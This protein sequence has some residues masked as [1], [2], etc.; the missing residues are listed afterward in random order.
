MKK[1]NLLKSLILVISVLL[2]TGK[3]FCEA[4]VVQQ[5][6]TVVQPTVAVEKIS[7][8]ES[9]NINPETG[10]ASDLSS[11]FSLQSNDEQ[12]F[13]VVYSTLTTL[14]GTTVSAFDTNNNLFFANKENPPTI[15]AVNNA[16]QGVKGNMNVI[17]YKMSLTGENFNILFTDSSIYDDCY[18]VS[19][20]ETLT[21]G[22]LLQT[23][24][25][26]P[27]VNT[28][29]AGEDMSGSYIVTVYVTAATKI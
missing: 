14:E 28:Y 20:K 15:A 24:G 10:V 2:S 17:G 8:M 23:V 25:G 11:S 4:T 29:G 9:G 7:S 13:F 3:A 12:T 16:K 6:Y 22:T 1:L 21:S 27:V 26:T 5:A 19:L 18:K